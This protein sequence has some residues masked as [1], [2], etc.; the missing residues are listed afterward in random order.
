MYTRLCN[1]H[2]Q[3][4]LRYCTHVPH[5]T[6]FECGLL[7]IIDAIECVWHAI[8]FCQTSPVLNWLKFV[9]RKCK[10]ISQETKKNASV[11]TNAA[12]GVHSF[13]LFML[14]P[15]DDDLSMNRVITWNELL[16]QSKPISQCIVET[17]TISLFA[18]FAIHSNH[19]VQR[20]VGFIVRVCRCARVCVHCAKQPQYELWI[21]NEII[22][23]TMCYNFH[24]N[25]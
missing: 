9:H 5:S 2:I 15:C 17:F 23:N 7:I 4:E 22:I 21:Y 14:F 16:S 12:I 18:L 3:C 6:H 19:Q 24:L 20:T 13:R 8:A 25:R 10:N 11:S 1:M